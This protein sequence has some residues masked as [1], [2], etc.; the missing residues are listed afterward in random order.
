MTNFVKDNGGV[1]VLMGILLAAGA[2]YLEWRIDTRVTD[3]VNTKG[4]ITPAQID[5]FKTKQENL[6]EDVNELKAADAKLDGKIERVVQILL[7]D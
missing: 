2:A 5:V 1:L 3:A 6:K 7:E 4:Y